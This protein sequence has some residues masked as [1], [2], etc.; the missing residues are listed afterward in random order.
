VSGCD[1]T[2]WIPT[3][4]PHDR[5]MSPIGRS[6]PLVAYVFCDCYQDPTLNKRHL[7]DM[8]DSNRS[9]NDPEGWAAHEAS[10]PE[11]RGDDE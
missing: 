8:H 11:C 10:C 3:N 1:E 7:Y 5:E 9:Y 2:C 4:C 6:V